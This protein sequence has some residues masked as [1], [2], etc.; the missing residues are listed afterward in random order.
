MFVDPASNAGLLLRVGGVGILL[1]A[2]I[3]SAVL[4]LVLLVSLLRKRPREARWAA[5]A[6]S[7]VLGMWAAS[8]LLTVGLLRGR[9]LAPGEELAF[10]GFDCHL[11]VGVR[12]VAPGERLGVT[13]T[14]RSDARQAP[15]YPALLDIAVASEDGRRFAPVAGDM[16]GALLAGE[17]RDVPLQFDVPTDARDLR[18]VANWRSAPAWLMPGPDHVVVQRRTGIALA[19]SEAR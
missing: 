1:L 15:E 8:M 14:L 11:H 13:L 7:S 6:L 16:G 10:C 19:P 9:T 3:G 5:T 17:S 2:I 18:L 12:S 4:L